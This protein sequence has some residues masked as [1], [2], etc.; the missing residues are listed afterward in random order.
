MIASFSIDAGTAGTAPLGGTELP[1]RPSS[2]TTDS[3]SVSADAARAVRVGRDRVGRLDLSYEGQDGRRVGRGEKGLLA[4]EPRGPLVVLDPVLVGT[5]WRRQSVS[6]PQFD[7][8][9]LLLP[10]T[11]AEGRRS[12]CALEAGGERG[13]WLDEERGSGDDLGALDL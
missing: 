3:I 11:P 12:R 6:A 4:L 2:I 13:E 1:R 8:V 5:A 9:I 7:E 10:Y